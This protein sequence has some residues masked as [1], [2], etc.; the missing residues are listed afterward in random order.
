MA[1]VRVSTMT[2]LAGREAEA[3]ELNKD[4]TT[5]YRDQSGCL[6]STYVRSV[7]GANEIGRVTFWESDVLADKAAL[8]ERSIYLR[9]RLHLVIQDGHK[10]RSFETEDAAAPALAASV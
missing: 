8:V 1:Y 6:S 5:F 9:S 2:P 4:L 7:D 10:D 3:E